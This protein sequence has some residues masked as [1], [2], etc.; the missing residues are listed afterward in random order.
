[1]L[2][3]I[4]VGACVAV[5]GAGSALAQDAAKYVDAQAAISAQISPSGR[6]VALIRRTDDVQQL[7]VIDLAKEESRVVQSVKQTSQYDLDWVRWKGDKRLVLGATI[8]LVDKGRAPTG[9]TI[10]EADQ[11]F[12]VSRVLAVDS[13]GKNPVQMFQGQLGRLWGNLGSTTLLDDLPGDPTHVL[14]GAFETSGFGAWRADVTNGKVEQVANGEF[15]TYDYVT[16]GAGYPVMR[17]D[18]TANVQKIFRRGSGA[19]AWVPAGEIRQSLAR[20]TP[21]FKVVSPGPGKNQVYIRARHNGDKAGIYLYDASTGEFGEP[22][23]PI[24]E[25]DAAL[26]WIDPKSRALMATCEFTARLACKAVDPKLQKYINA[27]DKFFDNSATVELV[28]MSDDAAKWLLKVDMPTEGTSYYVFDKASVQMDAVTP[29][30]PSLAGEKLSPTQVVAYDGRDGAKLWAYVTGQ[31][32]AGPRPMVVMPHGGPES[33]DA[34]GYDPMAQFLAQQGYVVVQP[35]F[36]GSSGYDEAFTAAGRNQWGKRMQDDVTDA[37]KHMVD[38]GLAD[39][40]R[41]CIV[42]ASYGG[43]AALAGATLTPDLYKCAVSISGVS[44]LVE[45]LKLERHDGG[46]ESNTFYYWRY[47]IGDPDKDRAALDAVSPA[48]LA[49]NVKVPVLLIHGDKDETVPVRQSTLMEGALRGAGKSVK[50]VRLP[51]A[52]HYWDEWKRDERLTMFQEVGAF[53][54]ANLN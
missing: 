45:M 36:R 39:P 54:K 3:N 19:D 5:L 21:D 41:I 16:D 53:L 37:V 38:A 40:K 30:Y 47:S 49:K 52:N 50:L 33:R 51:K 27:L 8:E 12:H 14:I 7:L 2:R 6:E 31:T 22:L 10:K 44:D 15:Q 11:V 32:G 42:G 35:N 9:Q 25:A 17:V 20:E 28:N 48:K 1:M 29:L 26:P 43:Y 34:Y 13:D 46:T 24:G 23:A 4:V 18:A